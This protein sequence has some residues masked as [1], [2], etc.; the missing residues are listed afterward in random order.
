MSSLRWDGERDMMARRAWPSA[1]AA[2]PA[3][4]GAAADTSGGDTFSGGPDSS[5]RSTLR[6]GE[7]ERGKLDGGDATEDTIAPATAV[8]TATEPPAGKESATAEAMLPFW[9]RCCACGAAGGSAGPGIDAT[10]KPREWL[11]EWPRECRPRVMALEP[12][13]ADGA[14][15]PKFGWADAAPGHS[16]L[17]CPKLR[18]RACAP[19]MTRG[20]TPPA[21]PASTPKAEGGM[22]SA[23]GDAGSCM[24]D[25]APAGLATPDPDGL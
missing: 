1:A 12:G 18:D 3:V 4:G 23:A 21:V 7:W 25:T 22:Q 6:Q 16:E 11:R 9:P 24:G 2:E 15:P 17:V 14:P 5:T 19:L 20:A 10:E 13:R 8:G